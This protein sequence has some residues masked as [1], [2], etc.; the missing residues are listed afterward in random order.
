[1]PTV[2]VIDLRHEKRV[3]GGLSETLRQ[4]MHQALGEGGQIILLLNR[5][6]YHTFVV[7]PRCGHVVKCHSCDVAVTYHREPSRSALPY[8]RCR[9]IV[10]SRLPR[11]RG[12][13]LP[14]W[15]NRHRATGA[16]DPVVVPEPCGAADGLGYDEQAGQ[17][18]GGAGGVQ[19]RGRAD[20]AGHADDC[21]GAGFSQCDARGG[22]QRRHGA[23]PARLSC[24]GAD[25]PA[26]VPGCRPDGSGRS[27]RPGARADVLLPITRRSSTRSATITRD[28]WGENFSS[29]RGSAYRRSAGWCG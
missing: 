6:G 7:C 22:G 8:L 10:P 4:A 5:R 18:R 17:P 16:G 3:Q 11:L 28:S 26:R 29:G 9:A 13:A 27:A 12:A 24:L 2:D 25:V 20:P 21:Q 1:M 15:W 14:L 23:A 19:G